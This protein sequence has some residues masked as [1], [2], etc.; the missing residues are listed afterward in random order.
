[1]VKKPTLILLGILVILG[2]F[3]WWY[4]KSPSVVESKI[5]PTPTSIPNPMADWKFENTR[6]IKYENPG[7]QSLSLRMGNDFNSWSIDENTDLPVDSSKVMQLLSELQSMQPIA[8]MDSTAGEEA[9]GLGINGKTIT[10]VESSGATRVIKFGNKTPTSSGSYIKVGNYFFIV[11]TP[12]VEN[13]I[14]LL[15]MEGIVKS[16]ELPTQVSGTPLP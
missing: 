2:A 13:I 1:M 8:K 3:T 11:N 14:G 12:V 6:L 5:T 4:Q 7:D 10:L 9:M 16:T 15:T